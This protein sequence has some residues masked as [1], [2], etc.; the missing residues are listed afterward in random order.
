[1]VAMTGID[2]FDLS[3]SRSPVSLKGIMA[4]YDDT[5]QVLDSKDL[6]HKAT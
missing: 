1:M 5:L 4:R 2:N 6:E 3:L